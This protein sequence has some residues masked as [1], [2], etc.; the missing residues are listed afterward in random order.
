MLPGDYILIAVPD[1]ALTG[2]RDAAFYDSASRLGTH[3]TIGEGE[4]KQIELRL[5]RG[6]R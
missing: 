3:L 6:L 1:D 2:D 4:R 5:V